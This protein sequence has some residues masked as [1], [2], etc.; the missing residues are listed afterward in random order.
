MSAVLATEHALPGGE[1]R[2]RLTAGAAGLGV[3]VVETGV[4]E[5]RRDLGVDRR[6]VVR[7]GRLGVGHQAAG[8]RAERHHERVDAHLDRAP[9]TVDDELG[10]LA[11]PEQHVGGHAA[12][13]EHLDRA[14]PGREVALDAALRL[15]RGDARE[16]VGIERLGVDADGV[17]ARPVHLLEHAQV[18]R[19]LELDLDRQPAR[20][21]DRRR[22]AADVDRAAVAPIERSG[23]ERDVDRVVE[24]ARRGAHLGE[25]RGVLT[26]TVCSP[27]VSSIPQKPHCSG[28]SQ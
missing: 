27:R 3:E 1:P 10:P 18:V 12:A 17:D 23:G 15:A 9:A 2:A 8:D 21:L 20:L 22:A 24:V 25:L 5:H 19:R 28:V 7:I 4:R 13:A 11:H 16:H 6:H 14:L 26:G